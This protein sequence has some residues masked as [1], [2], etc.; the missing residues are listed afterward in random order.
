MKNASSVPNETVR[1]D[2]GKHEEE[3]ERVL[4]HECCELFKRFPDQVASKHAIY[5]MLNIAQNGRP[6]SS[7]TKVR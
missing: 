1:N 4:S 7:R 6:T 3:K 5:L 2:V